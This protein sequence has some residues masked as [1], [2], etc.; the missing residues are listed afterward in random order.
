M[1]FW[2][3]V[4]RCIISDLP[5]FYWSLQTFLFKGKNIFGIPQIVDNQDEHETF[6]ALQSFYQHYDFFWENLWK[7]FYA[8]FMWQVTEKALMS[9]HFR[10]EEGVKSFYFL[11]YKLVWSS[12][13]RPLTY[14]LIVKGKILT[15]NP[16]NIRI[17]WDQ[18]LLELKLTS[19]LFDEE[20]GQVIGQDL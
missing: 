2:F 11:G 20:G 4:N 17:L 18:M 12:P 10:Y 1:K 14:T 6:T 3:L 9:R 5:R 19:F 7:R 8:F 15:I 16:L 13:I